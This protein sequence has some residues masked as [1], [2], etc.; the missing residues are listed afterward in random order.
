MRL[1]SQAFLLV[2]LLS[3]TLAA[4]R[5]SAAPWE[6]GKA[7]PTLQLPT[8]DGQDGFSIERYHGQKVLLHLF[9]SW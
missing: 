1:P 9:A 5:L 7:F 4:P 3:M 2:A 8:I 6:I